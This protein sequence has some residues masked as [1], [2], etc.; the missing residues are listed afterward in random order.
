MTGALAF[1]RRMSP[2]RQ[3]TAHLYFHSPCFDGVVSG[4]LTSEYLQHVQNYPHIELHVVNYHL[5]DAWVDSEL[6]RP[7]AVVDFLYHPQA[8]LWADHHQ[9]AFANQRMRLDYERRHGPDIFYDESASS[10][11]LLLWTRWKAQ[12]R[13]LS[14]RFE[15]IVRWADRID[16]AR[17]ESVEEALTYNTPALQISLAIGMYR[18]D[19]FSQHLVWL[20]RTESLQEIARRPEVRTAFLFG[21]HLQELG[22]ERLAN[23]IHLTQSGVAV[24]DVNAQ[25]VLVNRYV[26]FHFFPEARYSAG[27]VRKTGETKLTVMRNPWCEFSSAPLGEICAAS[28]GGGHQRVGSIIIKNDNAAE[29]LERVVA[30]IA[31]WDARIAQPEV[32]VA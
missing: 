14:E 27:I 11:A 19:G 30:Q 26:P 25:N 21:R 3:T 31:A 28:G 15:E 6:K 9:T 16:S 18:G 7:A 20:F 13:Y 2:Q 22:Q 1:L 8:E 4:A 5:R 24:F 10:C 32:A 17:Y 29:L 12:L 23:S